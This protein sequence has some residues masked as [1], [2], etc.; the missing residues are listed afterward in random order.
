MT[1]GAKA[2]PRL[3][4]AAARPR[5]PA[6]LESA[7]AAWWLEVV[8]TWDLDAHHVRLLTLAAEAF[9]RSVQARKVVARK[10]LTFRDRFGQPKARPEV[11]MERDARL[12][13]ARLLRELDLD[14]DGPDADES[15][16]PSLRRMR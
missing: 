15:R 4:D 11:A 13:F 3:A 2:G 5:A 7:T 1:T 6:H 10:G 16:P 12:S 14:V 9:D 8:T